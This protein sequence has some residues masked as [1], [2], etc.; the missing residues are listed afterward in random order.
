M[1][2]RCRSRTSRHSRAAPMG[3]IP[4]ADGGPKEWMARKLPSE[5]RVPLGEGMAGVAVQVAGEWRRDRVGNLLFQE[6]GGDR[7]LHV[8]IGFQARRSQQVLVEGTDEHEDTVASL[9]EERD[10]ALKGPPLE[11]RIQV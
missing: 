7:G 4:G 1:R 10:D 8:L 3:I 2:P 11:R 6:P 5:L 9:L